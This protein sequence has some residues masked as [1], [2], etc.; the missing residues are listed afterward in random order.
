MIT[1]GGFAADKF[2]AERLP[3]PPGHAT[4]VP[5]MRQTPRPLNAAD[6]QDSFFYCFLAP[7]WISYRRVSRYQITEP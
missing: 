7:S 6:V 4:R 5:G 2:L 3:L 1:N